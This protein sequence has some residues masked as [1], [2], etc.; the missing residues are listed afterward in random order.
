MTATAIAS[1][2]DGR[3]VFLPGAAA[4]SASAAGGHAVAGPGVPEVVLAAAALAADGVSFL[5][6]GSAALWLRSEPVT[7][8]DVGVAVKPGLAKL[9]WLPA[10]LVSLALRPRDVPAPRRLAGLPV[11]TIAISYGRVDRLL[12][13]GRRDWDQLNRGAGQVTVADVNFLVA[14]ANDAWALRHRF[15]GSA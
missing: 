6:V 12:D 8:A 10:A 4:A 13:R 11:V 2:R 3:G 1:S 14:S 9:R 5:L 15:K 7:V